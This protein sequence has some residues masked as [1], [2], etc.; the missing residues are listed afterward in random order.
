MLHPCTVP[1][2]HSIDIVWSVLSLKPK[3]TNSDLAQR[4]TYAPSRTY[5]QS[6]PPSRVIDA[7]QPQPHVFSAPRANRR[8]ASMF[9]FHPRR[10]SRQSTSTHPPQVPSRSTPRSQA[11]VPPRRARARTRP[12]LCSTLS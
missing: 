11:Y 5:S 1:G 4:A 12:L 3:A 6:P 7:L 10:T 8:P 9:R 2:L